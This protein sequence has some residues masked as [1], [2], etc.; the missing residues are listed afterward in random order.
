MGAPDAQGI[1]ELLFNF[2]RAN[3]TRGSVTSGDG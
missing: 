2:V 1:D 3:V